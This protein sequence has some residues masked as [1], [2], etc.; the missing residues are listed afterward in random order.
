MRLFL[1]LGRF[2]FGFCLILSAGQTMFEI[3]SDVRVREDFATHVSG[4]MDFLEYYFKI[5]STQKLDMVDN[6]VTA[7]MILKGL[8]GLL[9]LFSNRIANLMGAIHLTLYFMIATPVVYDFYH[10]E[11][12]DPE[13]VLL[14][15]G[16]M[17]NM[18]LFG[19]LL[20][21]TKMRFKMYRRQLKKKIPKSKSKKH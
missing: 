2:L 7:F 1:V 21:L 9:F 13:F 5:T 4:V 17:Q 20:F 3:I 10:Y 14:L 16:F 19:A 6:F 12:G 18:A 15:H 8:G 11:V